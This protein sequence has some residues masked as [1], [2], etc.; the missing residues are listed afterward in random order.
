MRLYLYHNQD[1]LLL[2]AAVIRIQVCTAFRTLTYVRS[3]A[4]VISVLTTFCLPLF[5]LFDLDVSPTFTSMIFLSSISLL[6]SE[7]YSSTIVFNMS[8]FSLLFFKQLLKA[9]SRCS[10]GFLC[11][12]RF[13]LFH[14]YTLPTF[15][16]LCYRN[17]ISSF[18]LIV[19]QVFECS[20]L[21]SLL[22]CL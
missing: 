20:I 11:V 2:L 9:I 16:T 15:L 17:I 6:L 7:K 19:C 5:N 1:F 12:T 22:N 10:L 3:K 8:C 14:S 4:V 13:Y 21:N 18:I